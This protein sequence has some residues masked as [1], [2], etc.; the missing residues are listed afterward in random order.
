MTVPDPLEE[1]LV[2]RH[3]CEV[4]RGARFRFGEN[5]L[6]FVDAV[7][8]ERIAEAVVS[9]KALL[10]LDSLAGRTFLD[11]G[12][13]SGL[14]SLAARILGAQVTSFDYDPKSVESTTEL[15]RRYFPDDVDWAIL[16]GSVLDAGF[17]G[18]LGEFDVVYSW[19]VLHHTG[20]MWSA[21]EMVTRPLAAD[22]ILAVA[23]YND[24]GM[25]SRLWTSVKR[26]YCRGVGARALC[27]LV[28]YPYFSLL[29]VAAG[30]RD[31][32]NPMAG[33]ARYKTKRGMSIVHDWR[34][35]LGGYPFE[36]A[37]PVALD[38]FYAARGLQPRHAIYTS[39]LGCNELVYR[40]GDVG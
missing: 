13:G 30:I 22:G 6:S 3:S 8:Q 28:F 26:F 23:I 21:L 29:T 39:R 10:Q 15:R 12:S 9:V 24:Q 14:F 25:R 7:D 17:I 35:W 27:K 16:H 34:D 33:F 11:V 4:E 2:V 31:H 19:G 5:W 32:G 18:G 36:V 37:S 40:R 1:P 20:D 38:R